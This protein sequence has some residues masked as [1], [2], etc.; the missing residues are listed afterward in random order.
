MS[1]ANS[2]SS[3]VVPVRW[4]TGRPVLAAAR[5]GEC[6]S[7]GVAGFDRWLGQLPIHQGSAWWAWV[8]RARRVCD[9]WRCSRG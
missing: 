5:V 4:L 2:P 6:P 8:Y 3:D 7:L 1:G 9:V